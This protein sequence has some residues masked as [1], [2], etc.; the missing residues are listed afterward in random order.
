[1]KEFSHPGSQEKKAVDLNKAIQTTI[2]IS[3]NEWKYV[4]TM[5]TRLDPD[6]PLVPC[7]AGEINQVLLNLVVNSVHAIAEAEQ[8]DGHSMG[9][10]TIA[11]RRDGDWVELSVADSGVGIPDHIKERV[12]DP[13]FTTKEVG[14]GT[15]QGLMLAHT[16]IVKKHGGKIWFDSEIGKGTTF[17]LRLPLS[18]V[19]GARVQRRILFVDDEPNLLMG[20]KRS[21][22]PMRKLW[23]MEFVPSGD[24][25]LR[26]MSLREFDAVVTDMRMPGMSGADLLNTIQ[27]QW[28]GTV[29]I[30][31]SDQADRETV[32]QAIAPA[33]QFLAKPC[34]PEQL[35]SVLENTL[36]LTDLLQNTSL[37][38]F[39]S[40]HEEYSQL[41]FAL[42]AGDQRTPFGRPFGFAD[43]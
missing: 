9:T 5:E 41:A 23:E 10:I 22:R 29:R 16:V 39:I 27:E 25:A 24:E 4:A 42:S 18:A 7:L 8:R 11:T 21:L 43:W 2:T 1:M 15:G 32:M 26:L 28:P 3:R 40:Q 30:V 33:H 13:F 14:K 37:K 17:Y 6:L 31:L 38:C 19:G 34:D 35:R 12:F 20:L 36:A